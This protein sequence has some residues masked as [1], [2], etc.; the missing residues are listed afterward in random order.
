MLLCAAAC[1]CVRLHAF[2]CCCMLVRALCGRTR[3]A[4]V[5]RWRKN[6]FSG[7]LRVRAVRLCARQQTTDNRRQTTDDRRQTTD[8]HQEAMD[9]LTMMTGV[10]PSVSDR[11]RLPSW[12]VSF[13]L[14]FLSRLRALGASQQRHNSTTAQ[15]HN[16]TT[17]QPHL[18]VSK[19]NGD[20]VL[21][22]G[23]KCR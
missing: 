10:T 12:L 6:P 18:C 8:R 7:V 3:Q 20:D 1:C 21:L 15:Q 11:G 16:S 23:S 13:S 5:R 19:N 17:A 22:T 14:F 2:V 4:P 9:T